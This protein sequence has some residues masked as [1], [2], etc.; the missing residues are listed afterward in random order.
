MA[1]WAGVRYEILD[2]YVTPVAWLCMGVHAMHMHDGWRVCGYDEMGCAKTT[3]EFG[4]LLL[5]GCVVELMHKSK[6]KFN[7]KCYRTYV[8]K[9]QS[10]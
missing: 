3:E 6:K 7:I 4:L 9:S 2:N 8:H 10:I 5:A 1:G